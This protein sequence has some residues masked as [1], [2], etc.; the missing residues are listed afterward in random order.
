M[1]G[2]YKTSTI[3][4]IS[5]SADFTYGT[6]VILIWL[7]AEVSATIIAASVPFYRPFFRRTKSSG[8]SGGGPSGRNGTGP[9]SDPSS[10]YALSNRKRT[11]DG[12]SMLDSDVDRWGVSVGDRDVN[13]SH[14]DKA[15]LDNTP[16]SRI[17]RKTNISVHYTSDEEANYPR[18]LQRRDEF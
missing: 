16:D 10:S 18:G 2:L 3:P 4:F 6:A 17:V 8:A 14:S 15:I 7:V 12:H 9:K 11:H 1:V 13:D 5:R